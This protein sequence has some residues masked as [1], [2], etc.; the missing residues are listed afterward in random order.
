MA[1]FALR[2]GV[3]PLTVYRWELPEDAPESRR[4]RRGSRAKLRGFAEGRPPTA[5]GGAPRAMPPAPEALER[6]L[7]LLG[8]ARWDDAREQGLEA[9]RSGEDAG[10]SHLAFAASALWGRGDSRGAL[11]AL[12][13]LVRGVEDGSAPPEL[14]HRACALAA[15]AFA[16]PDGRT[17]DGSRVRDAAARAL[18]G[19]P[20]PEVA[21]LAAVAELQAAWFSGDGAVFDWAWSRRSRALEGARRPLDCALVLELRAARAYLEGRPGEAIRRLAL[22]A[23]EARALGFGQLEARALC[24]RALLELGGAVRPSEVLTL[25]RKARQARESAAL[26][27]GHVDLLIAAAESEALLRSGLYREAQAVCE[28]ADPVAERI[29]WLPVDALLPRTRLT[30]HVAGV[31]GVARMV[32]RYRQLAAAS[33]LNADAP[34]RY[35]E[36]LEASFEPDWE[37]AIGHMRAAAERCG[38]GRPWLESLARFLAASYATYGRPEDADDTLRQLDRA[39]ERHPSAWLR[40]YHAH[41]KGILATR[42]G[43]H[44]YAAE[45]LETAVAIMEMAGDISEHARA[46]RGLAIAAWLR[47]DPEA[48]RRLEESARQLKSL[49]IEVSPAQDIGHIQRDRT[50]A[51]T[52]ERRELPLLVPVQR[53][54]MRGLSSEQLR[55]ELLAMA[56][57][58][59]RGASAALFRDDALLAR[60]GPQAVGHFAVEFADGVGHHYTLTVSG[61]PDEEIRALLRSLA[62]VASMALERAALYE[63][64]SPGEVREAEEE[65]PPGLVAASPAMRGLLS[66]LRRLSRSRATVLITGESGAGKEVAARALHTLSS[67]AAGPF[68]AFNCAAVPAELFDAQLFGHRKGAFTGARESRPGMIRAADRGTL[69]LDEV[70]ELPLDVQAKL[71]RFLENGEVQPLGADR[72]VEVDVRVV[73]ATHRDLRAMILERA[74]REDLFYRLQVVP[75]RVPPLRERRED[76]LPLARHF[77]EQLGGARLAPDAAAALRGH[78]WRGNVRELRN[79]LERSVA[80]SPEGPLTAAA[81]RFDQ[82]ER[83]KASRG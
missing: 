49:G 57:E 44:A 73:A 2:L 37:A 45:Q 31:E 56:R 58:I 33:P 35:L 62:A 24:R 34:L 52:P 60:L 47:G 20:D 81:L 61:D 68:V 16:A 12:A 82:G 22:A 41:L 17:F 71:L 29:R 11:A 13:P 77:L 7:E 23:R 42:R 10:L 5:R 18:E 59:A 4:P 48:E 36:G 6:L 75:L 55:R 83:S 3:S 1:E 78:P 46:Q 72:P 9:L 43:D 79:V 53:L 67:R 40:G 38:G 8:R 50:T 65:A 70:G 64:P 54:S 21:A 66:D 19:P 39:L 26:D 25:T 69:F 28:R 76:I 30:F 51:P 32:D 80:F 14:G 74:F 63:V 27:E 15:L